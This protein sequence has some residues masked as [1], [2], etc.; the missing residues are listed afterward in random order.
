MIDKPFDTIDEYEEA[1]EFERELKEELARYNEECGEVITYSRGYCP[2]PNYGDW[3]DKQYGIRIWSNEV[4]K[5]DGYK[6]RRNGCGSKER[7]HAHHIF[8]QADNP[9]IRFEVWNGITLC[10]PCHILFHQ[11]YG[12]IENNEDQIREFIADGSIAYAY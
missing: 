11:N 7:L 8:N 12:K 4:R 3:R 10:Q 1:L 9:G 6:C 5:R 2:I